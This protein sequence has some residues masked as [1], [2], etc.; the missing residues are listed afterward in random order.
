M[1]RASSITSLGKPQGVRRLRF[2]AAFGRRLV[3]AP[4]PEVDA[5]VCISPALVSSAAAIARAKCRRRRPAIG[6]VVQDLYSRGVIETDLGGRWL[7]RVATAAEAGVLRSCDGVVA[8]HD[9][10]KEQMVQKLGVNPSRVRVIRNWTHIKPVADFSRADFRL[11]MGWKPEEIVVLHAGA[12]GTKQGLSNVVRA[13]ELADRGQRGVRFV[14]LGDGGER[15]RLQRQGAGIESLTFM[16][17]LGDE[18]FSRA[19]RSADILLVNE[20]P[21]LRDMAVPSKLTSYFSAGRPVLAAT[22]AGST[23]ADELAAASAGVRVDPGAPEQLLEAAVNLAQDDAKAQTLG[24]NGQAF[25]ERVL[26]ETSAL[27]QYDDWI[28]QLVAARNH[29]ETKNA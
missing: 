22:D 26:S 29:E 21:G 7:G 14:L 16:D 4:W 3:M 27:A 15:S 23:A 18:D 19:L 11:G 28:Q 25:C 20:L 12:M 2:E 17:P 13:A 5:I 24:A 10:F 1:S 8:I 6:L 9:R